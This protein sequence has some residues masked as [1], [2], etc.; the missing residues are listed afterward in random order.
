MTGLTAKLYKIKWDVIVNT[1][2]GPMLSRC[3]PY[4]PVTRLSLQNST[5]TWKLDKMAQGHFQLGISSVINSDV[6]GDLVMLKYDITEEDTSLE[7]ELYLK[8][9]FG[10]WCTNTILKYQIKGV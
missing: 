3:N 8:G 10:V 6:E 9:H 5:K 4:N 7:H 2:L 1:C